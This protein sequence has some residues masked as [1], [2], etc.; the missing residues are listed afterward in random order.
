[1]PLILW[2]LV[3]SPDDFDDTY[4]FSLP[5][6]VRALR[7]ITDWSYR[8]RLGESLRASGFTVDTDIVELAGDPLTVMTQREQM[9]VD[10]PGIKVSTNPADFPPAADMVLTAACPF[11]D[12]NRMVSSADPLGI[13]TS[14]N[15]PHDVSPIGARWTGTPPLYAVNGT[16]EKLLTSPNGGPNPEITANELE[17]VNGDMIAYWYRIA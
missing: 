1:M 16:F 5:Q 8:I 11:S 17:N 14:F 10:Q 13:G 9:G 6:P 12:R 4:Y 7:V 15:C 3:G 2:P